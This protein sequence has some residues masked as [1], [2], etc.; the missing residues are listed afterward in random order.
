MTD[1]EAM[2]CGV[3]AG[4]YFG[5]TQTVNTEEILP[6]LIMVMIVTDCCESHGATS[7]GQFVISLGLISIDVSV[8]DGILVYL[9]F[10]YGICLWPS[11]D[12]GVS[13]VSAS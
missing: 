8:S 12:L 3:E 1:G 6:S 7:A 5:S 9:I 11:I 13:R 10:L 2:L 4:A